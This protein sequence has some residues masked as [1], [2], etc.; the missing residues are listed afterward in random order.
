MHLLRIFMQSKLG[1]LDNINV[2]KMYALGH[3]RWGNRSPLVVFIP[4]NA[5]I[6]YMRRN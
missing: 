2:L 6:F 1:H 5:K 3:E 4:Q